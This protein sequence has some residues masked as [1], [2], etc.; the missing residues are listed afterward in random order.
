MTVYACHYRG[1]ASLKAIDVR[2]I[3]SVVAMIPDF[4]VTTTGDIEEPVHAF[5]L[6][7]KLGLDMTVLLGEEDEDEGPENDEGGTFID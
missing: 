6:V 4:K 5:F 1:V 3:K 2:D 7:E